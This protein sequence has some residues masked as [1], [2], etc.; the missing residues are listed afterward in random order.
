MKRELNG[1]DFRDLMDEAILS[2]RERGATFFRTSVG[3][4]THQL[5]IEGWKTWPNDQGDLPL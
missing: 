5:I 2:L 4:M 1:S 3:S